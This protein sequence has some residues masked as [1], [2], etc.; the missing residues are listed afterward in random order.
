MRPP[1]LVFKNQSN[2]FPPGSTILE[3][4]SPLTQRW[5]FL[6][7]APLGSLGCQSSGCTLQAFCQT[8]VTKTWDTNLGANQ[9]MQLGTP[10]SL[11]LE[12]PSSLPNAPRVGGSSPR[13]GGRRAVSRTANRPQQ[14]RRVPRRCAPD[15][16]R[17]GKVAVPN[18]TAASPG[19]GEMADASC[20]E[21][22]GQTRGG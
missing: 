17:K 5:R 6:D 21:R 22:W 1:I 12:F 15:P 13:F 20:H 10:L 9:M 7:S 19:I 2:D 18:R 16:P 14:V 3:C 4:P 11:V 8:G